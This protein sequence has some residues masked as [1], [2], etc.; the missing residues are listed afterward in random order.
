M[1]LWE[2]WTRWLA[3]GMLGEMSRIPQLLLGLVAALYVSSCSGKSPAVGIY[4]LDTDVMR[5]AYIEQIGGGE[6]NS[7][8]RVQLDTIDS[9]SGTM[10]L[11]ADGT[12]KISYSMSGQPSSSDSGTWEFGGDK[13]ILTGKDLQTGADVSMELS[14][15]GHS[16]TLMLGPGVFGTRTF[17]KVEN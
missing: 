6:P 17:R 2:G 5:S 9:A 3:N 13:I 15:D 4:Q 10:E 11:N 1:R 12:C 14:F 8:Q 7:L 16:A